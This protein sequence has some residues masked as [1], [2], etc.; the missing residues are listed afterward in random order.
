MIIGTAGHI[1]HGKTSLVKALTGVDADRL[2]EEKARGIT[3]DLGFAYKPLDSGGVL[4]FVD[5]PGHEKLVHNMLAGATGIDHVLLVVAADDGPMPQTREHLAIVDLLGLARGVVALTKCDLV[6]A[7]RAAEATREVETLLAESTL[8]GAPLFAVSSRTG[9]GIAELDRHLAQAAAALPAIHAHGNFRMPVDRSFTLSGIGTVVTG[10][11]AA[12]RVA[13]GDRL[14]VSPRGLQVRVRSVHAQNREAQEAH[15]GQRCAL[16]LTGGGLEKSDVRRGDW[17]VAAAAHAACERIDTRLS[18]L[19]GEARPLAHWTPVHVHLGAS[20]VGARVALLEGES[21][22]PGTNA[23]VQLV[24]E[25]PIGALHGDRFIVRDQS[26]RRTLGG[27]VV[28]DPFAPARGRRKPQRLAVLDALEAG[29]CEASLARLLALDQPGG[30][31]LQWFATSWNLTHDELGAL[32]RA[33]PFRSVSG[34]ARTLAFAPAQWTALEARVVQTLGAHHAQAVDSPGLTLDQLQRALHVLPP[35]DALCA[36]LIGAGSVA[37]SGPYLRLPDHTPRLSD[38]EQTLWQKVQ[39]WLDLAGLSPPKIAE[40]LRD[41]N[42]NQAQAI[43]VLQKLCRMG[44]LYAVGRDYFVLPRHIAELAACAQALAAQSP[45]RL[46]TVGRLREATGVSRHL[47]LPLLEFFD[48]A[49]LTMRVKD[50]RRMR[51][52]ARDVFEQGGGSSPGG[53]SGL[54]NR[55]G[56]QAGPG[57]VRLPL[58][59][60]VDRA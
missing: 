33:M 6:D 22:A 10:T 53:A 21:V 55:V 48:R 50:G 60:A 24:L 51:R 38:A 35:L 7:A 3:L 52:D 41:R 11:I 36:G 18:L 1:D 32:A 28:L 43:A 8:A 58:S 9:E 44:E 27:G 30:I 31:D 47:S 56:P 40:L 16:N 54:Q 59:S 15:V 5:V 45:E 13:V 34:G 29:G 49:G 57:W 19:A 17:I 39:P 46:L 26:A 12:G 14:V 23:R 20:D 25:R 2:K 4:G 37:K 42:L